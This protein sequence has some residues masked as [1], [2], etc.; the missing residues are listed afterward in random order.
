M[1][2]ERRTAE[3]EGARRATGVSA[4]SDP[5]LVAGIFMRLPIRKFRRKLLEGDLRRPISSGFSKKRSV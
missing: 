2:A 4:V 5:P 3:M 1:V